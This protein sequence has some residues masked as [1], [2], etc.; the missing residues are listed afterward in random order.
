MVNLYNKYL[1][2]EKKLC[3]EYEREFGP[4]TMNGLNMGM[5]RWNWVNSPWPWEVVK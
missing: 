4:L 3:D 5:D 1:M 2:D